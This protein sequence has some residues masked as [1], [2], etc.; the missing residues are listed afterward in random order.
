MATMT[1]LDWHTYPVGAITQVKRGT[2]V[3]RTKKLVSDLNPRVEKLFSDTLV[4]L[5]GYYNRRGLIVGYELVCK[6][7]P[8]KI[9][10]NFYLVL[11]Y[12]EKGQHP[13]EMTTPELAGKADTSISLVKFGRLTPNRM[14]VFIY[15]RKQDGGS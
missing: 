7:K 9:H 4:T 3:L 5:N 10:E 8:A 1:K 15:R 12:V 14:Y 11:D 13:K 2:Y 6:G